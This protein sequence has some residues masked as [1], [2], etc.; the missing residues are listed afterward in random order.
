MNLVL[1][2]APGCGKGTHAKKINEK[3]GFTP[4]STGELF[5]QE[6][7]N[8]TPIGH[9]AKEI[10]DRGE[11]CPDRL[12]LDM[13]TEYI[14]SIDNHTGFILD[15]VPRTIEQ[16]K[17]LDGIDYD[18]PLS[19]TVVINIQV[20]ED[21]IISRLLKRARLEN[22]S[23]DSLDIIKNRIKTYQAYTEPLIHYYEKQQKL[24][25]VNGSDDIEIVF[26]RICDIINRYIE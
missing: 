25:Q 5:R 2:G 20:K 18:S 7:A 8:N 21:V 3:Y 6:I 12:T 19:I 11:L 24:F 26:A 15:G 4:L 22:R 23:D 9:H 17:M 10:L 14:H 1:L 16:A 13:L